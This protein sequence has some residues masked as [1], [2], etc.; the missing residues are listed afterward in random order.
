M[1]VTAV[2][3]TDA[4]AQ[5]G[6]N[7]LN[8][9]KQAGKEILQGN[10]SQ[11]SSQQSSNQQQS[12]QPAQQQQS[13]PQQTN[14]Q[15]AQPS[16]QTSKPAA[17]QNSPAEKPKE[18]TK[19]NYLAE[20]QQLAGKVASESMLMVS[21][22]PGGYLIQIKNENGNLIKEYDI[23]RVYMYLYNRTE[24]ALPSFASSIPPTTTSTPK[25]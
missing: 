17:K 3:A 14:N 21:L 6:K 24:K 4:D 1:I 13:A 2:S 20:A 12:Q 19:A 16:Q 8:K 18:Y 22:E 7:L 23:I 11:Q 10:D 5:I 25:G 9:A 15:T